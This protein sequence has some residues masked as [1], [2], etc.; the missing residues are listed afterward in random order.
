M[1]D[2]ARRAE[3]AGVFILAGDAPPVPLTARAGALDALR[4]TLIF[5]PIVWLPWPVIGAA[6]GGLLR[7]W[8]SPQ[9]PK[10]HDELSYDEGDPR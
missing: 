2:G 1:P 9:E 10:V 4:S 6:M 7:R 8:L 3:S 5:G